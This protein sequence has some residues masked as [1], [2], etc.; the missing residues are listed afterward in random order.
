MIPLGPVPITASLSFKTEI[1]AAWN[2]N[3]GLGIDTSGFY[4]DPGTSITAS[5]SITAGLL[6]EVS[7][8]KLAGMQVFA[9]VGASVSMTG[10]PGSRPTRWSY[11]SGRTIE[12]S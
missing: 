7:I 5:G 4:I 2:Y 1:Q 9:G 12:I 8:A 11:L 6:A 10:I 3:V